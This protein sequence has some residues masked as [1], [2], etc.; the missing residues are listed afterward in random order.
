MTSRPLNLN[1]SGS[2]YQI[3]A[4]LGVQMRIELFLSSAKPRVNR[5]AVRGAGDQN[6]SASD[7]SISENLVF[8]FVLTCCD[9]VAGWF[10]LRVTPAVTRLM[11]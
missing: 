1:F 9:C 7:N 4:R 8:S 6:G 5:N 2:F 10:P 3:I 11:V